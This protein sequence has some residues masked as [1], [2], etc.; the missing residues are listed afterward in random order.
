M[1]ISDHS[2][3]STPVVNAS[4]LR[5]HEIESVLGEEGVTRYPYGDSP[6]PMDMPFA[7][8]LTIIPP[9]SRVR[10]HIH[11]CVERVVV[12]DGLGYVRVGDQDYPVARFDTTVVAA[13]V[14]HGYRNSGDVPLIILWMYG[15]SHVTRTYVDGAEAENRD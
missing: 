2:R 15:S 7:T 11:N 9:G 13:N 12:L 14:Q 6:A 3:D 1:S 10:L 5:F 4:V 8:G